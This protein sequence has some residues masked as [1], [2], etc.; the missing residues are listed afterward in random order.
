[1]VIMSHIESI[2]FISLLNLRAATNRYYKYGTVLDNEDLMRLRVYLGDEKSTGI[3]LENFR[4]TQT[5][6]GNK[7]RQTF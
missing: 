7:N 4:V 6:I 2:D 5:G 3:K 1:M